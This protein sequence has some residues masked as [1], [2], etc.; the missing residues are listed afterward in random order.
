SFRTILSAQIETGELIGGDAGEDR[1]LLAPVFEIGNGGHALAAGRKRL[2]DFDQPLGIFE[3]QRAQQHA[4]HNAE[5]N[6]VRSN[7]ERERHHGNE[8][9][10]HV[11]WA[12][13]STCARRSAGPESAFQSNLDSTSRDSPPSARFDCRIAAGRR[14]APLPRPYRTPSS[15]RS[16]FLDGSASPLPSRARIFPGA[17][18]KADGDRVAK[19]IGKDIAKVCSSRAASLPAKH[20]RAPW[21]WPQSA[22]DRRSPRPPTVCAPPSSACS[23]SPAGCSPSLPIPP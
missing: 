6:G 18:A 8:P 3:R 14:N 19:Q 11:L 2:P 23:A 9:Q 15:A 10:L 7:A 4:I 21:R 16:A 12:P 13:S 17:A 1:V 20:F 22:G 5:D